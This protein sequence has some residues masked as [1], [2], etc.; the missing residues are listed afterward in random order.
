MTK[1]VRDNIKDLKN[2][3]DQT[4]EEIREFSF[5]EAETAYSNMAVTLVDNIK[6]ILP[7]TTDNANLYRQLMDLSSIINITEW[8]TTVDNGN[9]VEYFRALTEDW[10]SRIELILEFNR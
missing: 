6:D 9:P 8:D 1:A 5:D 7:D 2:L 10:V 4:E 3:I